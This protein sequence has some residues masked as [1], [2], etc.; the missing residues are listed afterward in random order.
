MGPYFEA[1][2]LFSLGLKHRYS[3]FFFNPRKYWKLA[4]LTHA[5]FMHLF[6]AYS[7]T[8]YIPSATEQ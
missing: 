2:I 3:S 1:C 6:Y 5:V 4:V 8:N 7:A